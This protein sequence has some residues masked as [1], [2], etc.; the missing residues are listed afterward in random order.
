MTMY[1]LSI[2]LCS[3]ISIRVLLCPNNISHTFPPTGSNDN[4]I[5]LFTP[6]LTKC[7]PWHDRLRSS[8]N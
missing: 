7:V 6:S 8:S 3:N 1:R 5:Q 4:E 2:K